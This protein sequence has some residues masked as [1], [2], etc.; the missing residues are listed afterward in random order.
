MGVEEEFLSALAK[1]VIEYYCGSQNRQY[2]EGYLNLKSNE[3]FIVSELQKEYKKFKNTLS[4][5][6]NR[7]NRIA[8][9]KGKIDGTDAFLLYQSFG[10]PIEIIKELGEEN[11]IPVDLE[12]FDT[13][14]EKHQDVSRLG[15]T[16]R[17]GSGLAGGREQHGADGAPLPPTR[18]PAGER[19]VRADAGDG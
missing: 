7:F 15:A 1:T 2:V 9:K 18:G 13:E 6:L 5:G 19:A 17:F 8:K 10:F 4:K 14:F 12:G 11:D 16:K 3:D